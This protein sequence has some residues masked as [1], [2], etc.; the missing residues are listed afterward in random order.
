MEIENK[1]FMDHLMSIHMSV[2]FT[3]NHLNE[4]MD[5]NMSAIGWSYVTVDSL[6]RIQSFWLHCSWTSHCH[7][8]GM[9]HIC[10]LPAWHMHAGCGYGHTHTVFNINRY[11]KR[12]SILNFQVKL[13]SKWF[14]KKIPEILVKSAVSWTLPRPSIENLLSRV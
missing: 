12:S 3:H 2:W 7:I 8:S 10:A 6:T 9:F 5:H 11:S 13:F 1:P 14:F 4:E